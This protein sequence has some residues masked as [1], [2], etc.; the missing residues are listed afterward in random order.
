MSM[1]YW[2]CIVG[3]IERATVPNGGDFPLRMAVR[4]KM[5]EMFGSEVENKTTCS[6]GWGMDQKEYDAIQR[7][8]HTEYCRR[9]NINE[10]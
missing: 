8:R 10:D 9:H 3:P 2:Y 7:A 1:E 5:S 6:S 4:E